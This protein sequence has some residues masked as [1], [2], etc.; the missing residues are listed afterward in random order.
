MS[1][2]FEFQ[3]AKNRG[4]SVGDIMSAM[5]VYQAL[6][7]NKKVLIIPLRK[8]RVGSD[9]E[10]CLIPAGTDS[11]SV[12]NMDL[13]DQ[14]S[15]TD[16]GI[17]AVM[18]RA[19]GGVITPDQFDNCVTPLMEEARGL[20][21]LRTTKAPRFEEDLSA[22][23]E[24]VKAIIT[25]AKT[26][27]DYIFVSVSPDYDSFLK[28][29]GELA[30]RII[31]V[32]RQG[33]KE[34][35]SETNSAFEKKISYLISDFEDASTWNRRKMAKMYKTKSLYILPHNVLFRDAKEN[36]E[37]IKFI[38]TNVN[39]DKND[40]NYK[41]MSEMLRLLKHLDSGAD[42]TDDAYTDP[43]DH[44]ESLDTSGRHT[45]PK[46]TGGREMNT[47]AGN[48]IVGGLFSKKTILYNKTEVR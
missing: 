35:V 48:R 42:E 46:L 43:L 12:G 19:G 18:R 22:N 37:T 20:D 6:R 5:A 47:S 21:I 8:H 10:D 2:I 23:W 33:K 16:T 44:T 31:L 36:G 29:I 7:T 4:G 30:D 1:M 15:F 45:R 3:G 17:D 41:L 26:M 9:I 28:N 39:V 40:Y 13:V 38:R 24:F 27:Y 32:A 11:G 25:C 34:P 14:F